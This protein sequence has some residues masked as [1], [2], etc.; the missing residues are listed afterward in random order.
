MSEN[1]SAKVVK[2]GINFGE[3]AR[4]VGQLAIRERT[5]YFEYDSTFIERGMEISPIRLPLQPGVQSFEH[6]L[7]EGLPEYLMIVYLMVGDDF[8]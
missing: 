1:L 5:I 3:G 8:C 6:D 4:P 7:F 2:V